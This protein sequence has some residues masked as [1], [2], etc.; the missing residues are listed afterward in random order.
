MVSENTHQLVCCSVHPTF[1][2][3]LVG[4]GTS[5]IGKP[6]WDFQTTAVVDGAFKEVELSDCRG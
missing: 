2:A 3:Q 1:P 4:L 5:H 6:A